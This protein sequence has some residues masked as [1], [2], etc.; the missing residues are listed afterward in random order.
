M[1]VKLAPFGLELGDIE[2]RDRGCVAGVVPAVLNDDDVIL[3]ESYQAAPD[4]SLRSGR[5][6][7]ELNIWAGTRES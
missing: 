7:T 6:M 5:R 3:I 1:G 4:C 2:E